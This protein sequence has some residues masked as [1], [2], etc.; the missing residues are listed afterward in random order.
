M[1]GNEFSDGV[2]FVV[3]IGLFIFATSACIYQYRE[4]KVQSKWPE[5]QG[6]VISWQEKDVIVRKKNFQRNVHET[7]VSLAYEF[8]VGE[9]TYTGHAHYNSSASPNWIP[10]GDRQL[11]NSE[12]DRIPIRV[13]YNPSNPRKSVLKRAKFTF[14]WYFIPFFIL[15]PFYIFCYSYEHFFKRSSNFKR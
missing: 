10:N 5:A 11:V 15:I 12:S 7:R 2:A 13:Y 6:Y 14:E 4:E 8:Q 1:F 9:N 3:S